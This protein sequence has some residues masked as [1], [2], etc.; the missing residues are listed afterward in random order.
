MAAVRKEVVPLLVKGIEERVGREEEAAA[1]EAAVAVLVKCLGPVA[2][3][4]D[5]S[6]LREV[7]ELP[8]CVFKGLLVSEALEVQLENVVYSLLIR[9][10]FELPHDKDTRAAFKE[11]APLL[12]YHHTA[13][14]LANVVLQCPRMKTSG[15]LPSVLCSAFVQREVSPQL[16][17]R[18]AIEDKNLKSGRRNRG[19][20][21]SEACRELTAS[22]T[23]EETKS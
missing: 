3:V 10:V 20:A 21:P 12:R 6:G 16:V 19:V 11:V 22:F 23:L 13:D 2:D 1:V 9:W 5:G 15:L 8:L 14:F 18:A 17:R 7:G 4:F